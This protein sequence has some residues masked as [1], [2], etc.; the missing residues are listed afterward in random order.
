MRLGPLAGLVSLMRHAAAEN[1]TAAFRAMIAFPVV[2]A[3]TP[4][5]VPADT[6]RLGPRVSDA[7]PDLNSAAAAWAQRRALQPA[8]AP[9]ADPAPELLPLGQ[10]RRDGH[11]FTEDQDAV[12][13]VV[14][15]QQQLRLPLRLGQVE[16]PLA[17]LNEEELQAVQVGLQPRR[18]G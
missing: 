11:L 9:A 5:A 6:P 18:L 14:R 17:T 8:A 10:L 13:A 3:G 15:P 7:M 1:A 12:P 4:P 2:S 16:L